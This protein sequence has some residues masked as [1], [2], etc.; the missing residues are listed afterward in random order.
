MNHKQNKESQNPVNVINTKITIW[1]Y[2]IFFLKIKN[3]IE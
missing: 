2:L 3:I 1:F